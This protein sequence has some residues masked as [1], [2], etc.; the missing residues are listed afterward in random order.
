[1]HRI[2]F[3]AG[4]FTLYSYG[5][6]MAASFM[7]GIWMCVRRAPAFGF[8][9]DQVQ[10]SAITILLAGLAGAKLLFL[11]T[12]WSDVVAD[13]R[14][15]L[16]LIRGGFVFYGGLIGGAAG[17]IWWLR[18]HRLP[19]W[20]FGDL[21]AP[22]LAVA[23]GIGRIGCFF[24]GC[25]YG[26]PVSWGFV[27]PDLGD[28]IPRHP[29]QLYE[30]AAATALGAGLW[31]MPPPPKGREGRVF[32]LLLV[33]YALFRFAVEFLRADPRGPAILGLSPSQWISL[34]GLAIGGWLL[35]RRPDGAG[36]PV[37]G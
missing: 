17:A 25:C 22:G 1:M 6:A 30:F 3:A 35:R 32:G 18:R 2:L 10:D 19:V 4:P 13:W 11:C 9:A 16:S 27:F 12:N 23:L 36:D 26:G 34:P 29:T 14:Q 8:T 24:N 5:A 15:I 37:R 31:F 28:G 21:I 20:S 33:V 7:V